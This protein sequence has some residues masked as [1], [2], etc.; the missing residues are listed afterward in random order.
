[1]G[2]VVQHNGAHCI[3]QMNNRDYKIFAPNTFHHVYNR[4]NGKMD[5]FK[6]TQDFSN[7]YK[8]LE[9]VIGK[10]QNA[11]VPIVQWAPLRITRFAKDKFSLLSYSLM[12]NHFHF[13][14]R[15]NSDIPVSNFISKLCSSYEK[16]FN[17]K[18]GHVGGLF[19][20]QF[21]SV[22]IENDSYLLWLS[23]YIHQNP[24]VAGLV[25]DIKDY[26][27]S[28]YPDY[29]SSREAGITDKNLILGIFNNNYEKYQEFVLQ[30]F[31]KIIQQKTLKNY[32][33]D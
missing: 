1:M 30:S 29:C 20:D 25:R 12:P 21:K 10:S 18:Y 8:R 15:Q 19:Q 33:L 4:G 31:E 6:D 14:I 23:A 3:P 26:P 5:I 32:L 11:M 13:L 24:V 16:Y 9:I 27:Y 17:K 2:T 7:F 22:L 28:S